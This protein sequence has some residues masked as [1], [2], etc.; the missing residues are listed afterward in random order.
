MYIRDIEPSMY[1]VYDLSIVY[2]C[3]CIHICVLV[4]IDIDILVEKIIR[5]Q[6]QQTKIWSKINSRFYS[7]ARLVQ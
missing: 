7:T 6:R 2:T 3:T 1:S 4:D 5:I